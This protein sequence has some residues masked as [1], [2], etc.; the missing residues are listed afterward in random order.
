MDPSRNPSPRDGWLTPREELEA[1]RRALYST[2][3]PDCCANLRGQIRERE[4]ALR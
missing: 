2:R 4:A 1:L 3:C